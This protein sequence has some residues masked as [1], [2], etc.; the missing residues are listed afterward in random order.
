MRFWFCC[1]FLQ[2]GVRCLT[3]NSD[4]YAYGRT[5]N[6]T[7]SSTNALWQKAHTAALYNQVQL[8]KFPES[9]SSRWFTFPEKIRADGCSAGMECPYY[10]LGLQFQSFQF[11]YVCRMRQCHSSLHKDLSSKTFNS[12]DHI[13]TRLANENWGEGAF[14]W[15]HRYRTP[16]NLIS[17][18]YTG[19][20][21]IHCM[22]RE[23]RSRL[24]S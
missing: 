20:I 1:S 14:L 24:H 18:S 22:G 10:S 6:V 11:K 21:G 12:G 7:E 3:A 15:H 8:Q 16:K 13:I 9:N 17:T 2:V 4:G 23:V 19:A 5:P